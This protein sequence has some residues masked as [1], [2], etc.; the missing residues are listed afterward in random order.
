MQKNVSLAIVVALGFF[1]LAFGLIG[2]AGTKQLTK[3]T[4]V[5]VIERIP[6]IEQPKWVNRAEEFWQD[7]GDFY[8]KG[9]SEG[10]TDLESSNRSAV[11]TSRTKIG[12]M[13]KTTMRG[14]FEKAMVAGKYDPNV[15]GSLKDSFA[16]VTD[17]I[18]IS[19]TVPNES[20][21][22]KISQ[23]SDNTEKLY[24]R[25]YMLMKLS[26]AEYQKAVARV[27]DDMKGQLKAN[28]S[29]KQAAEET[30]NRLLEGIKSK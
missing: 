22:E 15:G 6:N 27:F 17:N 13:V 14:E 26:E 20:Y 16:S 25:T 29:A 9:V 4:T 23:I 21:S 1:G 30:K 18:V 5:T 7:K 8:Y 28:E 3:G 10:Y 11:A 19:G 2:C 24:Y 12:E